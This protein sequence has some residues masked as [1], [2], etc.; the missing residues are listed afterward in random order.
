MSFTN[1]SVVLAPLRLGHVHRFIEG[2]YLQYQPQTMPHCTST[3]PTQTRARTRSGRRAEDYQSSP[4]ESR[5]YSPPLDRDSYSSRNADLYN[6]RGISD[7]LLRSSPEPYDIDDEIL[8]PTA[9]YNPGRRL[10]DHQQEQYTLPTSPA[11]SDHT[12]P[13]SPVHEAYHADSRSS[14]TPGSP[15]AGWDLIPYYDPNAA[16]RASSPGASSD[17]TLVI[18]LPRLTVESD[19][20]PP[21]HRQRRER[22]FRTRSPSY[23]DYYPRSQSR[24]FDTR[25]RDSNDTLSSSPRR[26]YSAAS[27]SPD[28]PP[29]SSVSYRPA[30]YSQAAPAAGR[31]SRRRTRSRDRHARRNDNNTSAVRTTYIYYPSGSTVQV[32]GPVESDYYEPPSPQ[33]PSG[34]HIINLAPRRLRRVFGLEL[35]TVLNLVTSM[36]KQPDNKNANKGHT[37]GSTPAPPALRREAV[38]VQ[39]PVEYGKLKPH[40]DDKGNLM[41]YKEEEKAK[42]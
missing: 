3:R 31:S 16:N 8:S 7:G 2:S 26:Y 37:G 18:Q 17:S 32:D 12:R 11:L 38:S 6:Y 21:A 34:R 25:R 22:R 13:S 19:S 36:S 30:R 41:Q 5:R 28:P 10:G 24:A 4:P 29:R 15:R 39:D 9:H 14:E 35:L 27:R 40:P 23:T 20:P 42:K 1:S 33:Y